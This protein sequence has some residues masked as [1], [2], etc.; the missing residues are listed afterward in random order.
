[1]AALSFERIWS[2]LFTAYLDE[3][4]TGVKV[5]V[6]PK[7]QRFILQLALGHPGLQDKG[8]PLVP[9]HSETSSEY[10][11]DGIYQLFVGRRSDCK[12]ESVPIGC[13]TSG[14][15]T[16]E[17]PQVIE[18]PHLFSL[19]PESYPWGSRTTGEWPLVKSHSGLRKRSNWVSAYFR[20]AHLTLHTPVDW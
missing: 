2:K 6:N 7:R 12:R 17:L 13:A 20:H 11:L 8:F 10:T 4:H 9:T 5:H 1:M 14:S 18:H 19:F 3:W 15:A 16:R